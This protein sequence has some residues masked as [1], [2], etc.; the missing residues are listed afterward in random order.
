MP[1]VIQRFLNHQKLVFS[2]LFLFFVLCFPLGHSF[3]DGCTMFHAPT[4]VTY[5]DVL[6]TEKLSRLKI[7]T[8]HTY[9]SGTIVTDGEAEHRKKK[10]SKQKK[11]MLFLCVWLLYCFVSLFMGIM[12]VTGTCGKHQCFMF[13]KIF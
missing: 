5:L 3:S 13:E 8:H 7:D 11:C 6:S 9:T 4:C 10:K 1:V 12:F 2:S